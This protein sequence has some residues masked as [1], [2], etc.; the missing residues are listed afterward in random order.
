[1][2]PHQIISLM[3]YPGTDNTL[4]LPDH[5]DHIHVGYRP[6]STP[7]SPTAIELAAILRPSQWLKL[8]D[9]LGRIA[10]P[11][12]TRTPSKYAIDTHLPRGSA[13]HEDR[14]PR[15]ATLP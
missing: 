2:K 5:A 1:M 4:A 3:T 11:V 9:R 13:A 6:P 10:N 7:G 8:I 14:S 15:G 12:V